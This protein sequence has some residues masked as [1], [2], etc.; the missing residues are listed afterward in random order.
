MAILGFHASHEQLAPSALLGAVRAAEAAGFDAGMCSDHLAPWTARQ[1]HSG[2]AWSW[3]GAALEATEL[4]FGV[5]TAPGQRY[6]PAVAAQAIATLAEMYPGRFWAALGSG[7][8]MNEHVTGDRWP[9]KPTRDA[10]LLECVEVI[11]ALLAGD[12]VTH[13]GLVA[14]DRARVW[15]LP[16]EPPALFGA[17][18]SAQTAAV[19]GSWADGLITVNQPAENLRK[20]IDAFREGGGEGKPA[21]L[22]VHLS[23]A[24]DESDALAIAH[25]QWASGA[26]DSSLAWNLEL[27]AQFEAAAAFV[28][29]DDVRRA[30]IVS[31]DL[32]RHAAQ[33]RDL[34]D[35]GF[36]GLYLHHVGQEQERFIDAFG[37]K[38]LPELR[39]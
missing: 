30:V 25:D 34:L 26:L 5:V 36:D 1:G 23:W 16:S 11:R 8:A 2:H 20:V 10:R 33:L 37:A 39:S 3:L 18:V 38:V 12:E 14:V 21:Y 27:P 22:Q 15:S 29:P 17:A 28:R 7:E 4:S 6:H 31:S 32:G 9:D 24:E 19:V 13:R 35:A